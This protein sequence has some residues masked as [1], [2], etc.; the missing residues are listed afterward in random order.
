[1]K[2]SYL[3]SLFKTF[4]KKDFEHF[5]AFISSSFINPNPQFITLLDLIR[6]KINKNESLILDKYSVFKIIHPTKEFNDLRLRHSISEFRTLLDNYLVFQQFRKD[7]SLKNSILLNSLRNKNLRANFKK[8]LNK[9]NPNNSISPTNSIVDP[10]FEKYLLQK[11]VY[12]F[13]HST[14]RVKEDK[15]TPLVRTLDHYYVLENIKLALYDWVNYKESEN[16]IFFKNKINSLI[17]NAHFL[18]NDSSIISL[19]IRIFE[20][21]YNDSQENFAELLQQFFQL[22]SQINLQ[23]RK[24]LYLILINYCAQYINKGNRD[25]A[26]LGLNLYM[27]GLNNKILLTEN[28]LSRFTYKNIVFIY[29]T[30]KDF[31]QAFEFM[32][33]FT[34]FLPADHRENSYHYNLATTY[35]MQGDYNQAL[36]IMSKT[37]FIDVYDDLNARRMLVRIYYEREEWNALHS[38]LDAFD[39]HLKRK[40]KLGIHKELFGYLIKYTRKT[41][42]LKLN[43]PSKINKLL[44]EINA[45]PAFP[46]KPWLESRLIEMLKK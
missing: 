5:R 15:I 16:K 11:E 34:K 38:C 27:R 20:I 44:K 9:I 1:M 42:A 21:L 8:T 22:E 32:N 43:E 46:E 39:V 3:N 25:F 6:E 45:R 10:L 2:S 29:L 30:L 17:H 18:E 13:E 40:T 7:Q 28:L 24:Y 31:D 36:E 37:R 41:L 4:Q 35:F 14:K 23:D 12:E 33:Q 26:Y 19:Y